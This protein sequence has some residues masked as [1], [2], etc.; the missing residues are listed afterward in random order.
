MDGI[1]LC[2]N[3]KAEFSADVVKEALSLLQK[4][5]IPP[6]ALMRTAII[7][8]QSFPEVKRFVLMETIPS[9]LKKEVWERAPKVWE[10]VIFGMKNLVS[11]YNKASDPTFH[12]LCQIPGVQLKSVLKVA[13]NLSPLLI[14]YLKSLSPEDYNLLISSDVE[15][16][17]ILRELV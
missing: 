1:A 13:T 14:Q 10:G 4:E 17:K 7:S 6:F 12:G 8:A 9:M 15:R 5:E 11:V 2:L 3:S 16:N